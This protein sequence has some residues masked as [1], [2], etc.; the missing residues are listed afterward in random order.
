MVERL[1]REDGGLYR[2]RVELNVGK[3][4]SPVLTELSVRAP[5]GNGSVVT[6]TEGASATLPCVF[7][8]YQVDHILHTVTWVRKDPYRHIVTFTHRGND[9]WTAEN[10]VTRYEL[11]RDP[12]QGNASTRIKQLSAEDSDGYLCLVE[13]RKP[14]YYRYPFFGL[15]PD[16]KIDLPFIHLSQCEVRLRVRAVSKAFPVVILCTPL[17]LKTLALLVMCIVFYSDNCRKG[18]D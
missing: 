15:Y 3:F 11:V 14:N 12:E 6:G 8:R 5:D 7:T 17:G 18:R 9:S 13:F 4:Q 2:C 16:Y 10:G 1:N